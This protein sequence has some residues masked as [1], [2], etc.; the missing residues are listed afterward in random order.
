MDSGASETRSSEL[1]GN[2]HSALPDA[3]TRE[4]MMRW[5]R[6][7]PNVAKLLAEK[8]GQTHR[9]RLGKLIAY[10]IGYLLSAALL[11]WLIWQTYQ[12]M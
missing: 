8:R 3:D 10:V 4:R 5:E 9:R 1:P 7:G 11:S 6:S 12:A 2:L